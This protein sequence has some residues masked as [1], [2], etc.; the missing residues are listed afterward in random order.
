IAWRTIA[1][2]YRPDQVLVGICLN[3]VPEMQNNLSRPPELLAEWYERSALVRRVMRARDREIGA[4]EELFTT[5]D[6][7]KVHEGYER[8]FTD[9]RTLRNEVSAQGALFG[10]LV[11]PFRFQVAA[12]APV[13]V[14]QRVI[15]DFCRREGIPFLDLLPALA[16]LGEPAFHD[17]D[18][19][20]PKG[21]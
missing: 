16:R 11:F 4:V 5:P 17:Y 15:G 6:A 21:A 20:S 3:D 9:L 14:A 13:P 1:R 10:V 8:M 12:D 7:P 18:H 19:L 2:R